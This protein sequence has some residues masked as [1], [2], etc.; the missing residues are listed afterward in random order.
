MELPAYEEEKLCYEYDALR[1]VPFDFIADDSYFYEVKGL[2]LTKPPFR[3]EVSLN[4]LKLWDISFIEGDWYSVHVEGGRSTIFGIRK[5]IKYGLCLI[6]YSRDGSYLS[7][8]GL[9]DIGWKYLSELSF[10]ILVAVTLEQLNLYGKLFG[11]CDFVIENYPYNDSEIELH[12]FGG[13][14]NMHDNDF[15]T[16]VPYKHDND[17]SGLH[18]GKDAKY[19]ASVVMFNYALKYYWYEN[20]QGISDYIDKNYSEP[21]LLVEHSSPE[22][23]IFQFQSYLKIQK[24]ERLY[25]DYFHDVKLV[26]EIYENKEISIQER[27]K[28]RKECDSGED[29]EEF[30]WLRDRLKIV[31]HM[32]L[33]FKDTFCR[34]LPI[35]IVDKNEDGSYMVWHKLTYKYPKFMEIVEDVVDLCKDGIERFALVVDVNEILQAS[36]DIKNAFCGFGVS[37]NKLDVYNDYEAIRLFNNYLKQA[38]SSNN[39]EIIDDLG[40]M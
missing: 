29:Y 23:N 22:M 5:E 38:L 14:V 25:L 33:K 32:Q 20:L 2:D 11:D 39:C 4:F 40:L 1:G 28:M 13:V 6:D 3:D 24:Y 12:V 10:D 26:N 36:E 35:F 27:D 15:Y 21:R 18:I 7:Y 37:K 16:K 30:L 8:S 34:K 9:D 31:S 19:Y 17:Y